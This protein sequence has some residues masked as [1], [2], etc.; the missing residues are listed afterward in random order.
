VQP[1]R[2]ADP[3]PSSAHDLVTQWLTCGLRVLSVGW[4]VLVW[5]GLAIQLTTTHAPAAATALLHQGNCTYQMLPAACNPLR[6]H[7]AFDSVVMARVLS[8][9]H[10]GIHMMKTHGG[11]PQNHNYITYCNV[12]TGGPRLG[13]R[14]DA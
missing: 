10:A 12:A 6:A 9:C 1:Y 4:D 13:H 5:V 14:Q 8:S 3:Q 7:A 11:H 2:R